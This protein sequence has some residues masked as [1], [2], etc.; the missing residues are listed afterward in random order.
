MI[1]K[2]NLENHKKISQKN[3]DKNRNIIDF[4]LP[5]KE[6]SNN[7]NYNKIGYLQNIINDDSDDFDSTIRK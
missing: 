5:I 7:K 2:N 3:D 4:F 1:N 6:K